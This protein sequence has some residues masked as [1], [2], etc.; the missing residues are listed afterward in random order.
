MSDELTDA[1]R[2]RL[3]KGAEKLAELEQ[4]IIAAMR[5]LAEAA[6]CFQYQE[7]QEQPAPVPQRIPTH[8]FLRDSRGECVA[9]SVDGTVLYKSSDVASYEGP[10]EIRFADGEGIFRTQFV[11]QHDR[12]FIER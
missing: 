3:L 8:I 10:L 4:S 7:I 9:M 12:W 2:E 5:A 11:D 6:M 1:Q